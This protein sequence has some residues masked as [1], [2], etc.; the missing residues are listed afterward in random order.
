MSAD[1]HLLFG[2]LALQNGLINQG[3][4]VAAFQAWT[5]D[6]SKTLALHLEA[7]GDLTGA[8]RALVE[9]LAEVHREVHDGDDEKSLAAVAASRSTR[10]SLAG[11][12]D[13]DVAAT[14]GRVGSGG[15]LTD[16]D[17]KVDADRTT[18]YSFG[19]ATSDGQRFR[20]VRPHARGGLGAVFVA[21]DSELHREVAL[22][23]I[24]EQHADDPLS[25]DRFIAEA[26]IT[27]ALEHPGVVPVYGLGT[28]DRGRPYYAMRF[29]Q[30]DSLKAAI[31]AFHQRANAKDQ[32]LTIQSSSPLVG[33]G[34]GGRRAGQGGLAGQAPGASRDLA[35]HKLLRR[36]TDVCN[37]IDYAHSRG[38]IHRDIKPANIIVGRH[39]ETLVVDWGL[40][41]SVGRADPSAGEATIAPSSSGSSETLPG[42][43]LGTPAYMSPEQAR[44]ELS[45]LGPRSDVYSLGA[46]LYCLLCGKP[47]F[48]GDDVGAILIAVQSGQFPS[49]SRLDPSIDKALEAVCQKA[50]ATAAENRYPTARALA[51]DLDRWMADEPVTAWREPLTR[52]ARRWARRNRTAVA[53]AV[54]ASVVGVVGLAAVAAVQT[55]ARADIARALAS[56]TR[57]NAELARSKAAVQARYDLAVEAI[58]TFHTGV[59]EDFLLKEDQFKE[60]RDRLLKSASDFYGKL[61]A[62]LGKETDVGSRRALEQSNFELAE[63][64]RLVGRIDDALAAHR[65][66]LAVREALAAETAA[67]PGVKADVGRSMTAVAFLLY[68]TGEVDAALRAYRRSESLLA[69]VAESDSE[70]LA[71]LATCRTRMT[72][73]LVH[74]GKGAE[75]L[76]AIKLARADREALAAGP[77][78]SSASRRGLADT[79]N[80]LG[81]VLWQT[82][83]PAEA[84]PEFR[85]A[86]AIQQKLADENPTDTD[87]RKF[88][89]NI[90]LHLGNVLRMTGKVSE[91]EAEIRTALAIYQ[92][93]SDKNPAVIVFRRNSALALSDLALILSQ[94][95]R[96]REAE[97]AWRTAMAILQRLAEYSPTNTDVQGLLANTHRG[98]GRELSLTGKLLEAEAE[99][100]TALAIDQKLAGDDPAK[101]FFRS[102]EANSHTALGSVLL[103]AGKLSEAEAESR[104]A[105]AINQKLADESPAE[106]AFR[107][108]IATSLVYLGDA[109]RFLGR[110]DEAKRGYE[111]AI[112]LLEP[113]VQQ[114]PMNAWH[115]HVLA[116]SILRRGLI[117]R[118]RADYTGAAADARRA[119][120]LCEGPPPRSVEAL[121]ETTCCHAALAGLAARAASGIS[122]AEG[123]EE[124]ARAME[125]L[126]RVVALGYRNLHGLEIESAVGP[127]RSRDDF[128]LLMMDLSLPAEPFVSDH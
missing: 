14:L 21:I 121:L 61:G 89:G 109:V 9:A 78:A 128:Q 70:A 59:S 5:L 66:V 82:D 72:R 22:K 117:L 120:G 44:G 68:E 54:V 6:K 63:L 73:P 29:I 57:A 46:T 87:A 32:Q 92:K 51:D 84:E 116:C 97:V 111:R 1:R 100:R 55:R 118:D 53:A 125:S 33:D 71:A 67:A 62:L 93:L 88:L 45:R 36:F 16:H 96:L 39:G 24:L 40:A 58:K 27:G 12:I 19:A 107:D 123:E 86:L 106:T 50:M 25:R 10:A 83:R 28:D 79:L 75:A 60:L 34:R 113:A 85:T 101:T 122:A 43:A 90:H 3:Q 110:P 69:S 103:S 52:R 31:D 47:P 64:T 37:A 17:G 126:R 80:E 20:I 114:N 77:G 115:R 91:A 35:L 98:L 102:R 81:I 49:P 124:A 23:Q 119:L 76:A 18:D 42:S 15:A 95:A 105:L 94:T 7:R 2:L 127:L 30:G 8:K 56:E 48:E 112:A 99:C 74:A 13:P 104:T 41:K 26:E 108:G 4:L 11:L 65:A 38:V